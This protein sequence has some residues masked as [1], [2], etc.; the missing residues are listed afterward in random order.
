MEHNLKFAG[1]YS[2]L[3]GL[4]IVG[5]W[6]FFLATGGVP[7]IQTEPLRIA[8]HLV[9]EIGMALALIVAG[10]AVRQSQAWG[11]AALLIAL[12]MLIYTVVVSPGYFAQQGSW[13]LVGMFAIVLALALP[14]AGSLLRASQ[15]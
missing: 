2:I 13:A 14:S 7:E 4:L 10:R 1:W 15:K 6:T 5:Q 12:G 9:A 8:F 3:V 11:R